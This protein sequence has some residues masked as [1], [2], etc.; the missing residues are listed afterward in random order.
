MQKGPA[1][2]FKDDL[3]TDEARIRAFRR[4]TDPKGR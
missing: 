3:Q 2:V 1:G 4:A